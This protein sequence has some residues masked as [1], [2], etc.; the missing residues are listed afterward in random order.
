MREKRQETLN[1]LSRAE[2]VHNQKKIFKDTPKNDI[3]MQLTILT[4]NPKKQL[5]FENYKQLILNGNSPSELNELYSKH[6]LAFYSALAKGKITLTKEQFESDYLSGIS[7]EEISRLYNIPREHITYLRKYYGIKRKGAKYIKRLKNEIPLTQ[8]S[9]DI[10]I[11]S[12][13]G[14]GHITPNGYFLEKHSEKQYEYLKWKADFLKTITTE[15]SWSYYESIEKRSGTL[16]KSRCF[17]TIT[18]NFLYEMRKKFYKEINKKYIKIIPD[19]IENMLNKRI[20]AIWFMDDG[21]TDWGYRNKI[22]VFNCSPQCKISS[23]SFSLED[24]KK[25]TTALLNKFGL[26]TKINAR[27]EIRF[28]SVSS[29]K[30]IAICKPFSTPCTLYKFDR[31]NYAAQINIT[32]N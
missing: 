3:P 18:H 6:L 29:L 28:N 5:T 26:K 16:I 24:N 17:R 21:C 14:D 11:G 4:A 8:E 1:Q 12:L 25:L 2:I 22:R 19:D 7:L 10:I 23:Q 9:K 20:L 31:E 13:L 27:R 30:L 32:K 15:K